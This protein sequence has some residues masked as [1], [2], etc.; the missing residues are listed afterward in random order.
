MGKPK[1]AA[2]NNNLYERVFALLSKNPPMPED[3]LVARL[4]GDSKPTKSLYRALADM[5]REGWVS[6]DFENKLGIEARQGVL[7][8]N[9]RGFGFVVAQEY[10]GDDV[11]IP[12]RLLLSATQDDQ[13][14][15]WV[16]RVAG[17]PGP[18]GRIMDVVIR[19]HPYLVGRLDRLHNGGWRVVPRD[20]RLPAV[21][22]ARRANGE[23]WQ[24]GLIVSC[25]ITRWPI[26]PAQ[27]ARGEVEE[28]L[29][30]V[31]DPGVDMKVLMAERQIKPT[32]PRDVVDEAKSLPDA[33]RDEDCQDREDLRQQL[34]V[35]IDGSDAKDLDDAISVQRTASGYRVGVHIADVSFYV[36]EDSVLDKEARR[37]GT[38]VYL[39]DRVVPMLP[40]RLSNGIAS[41]NPGVPRL[42]LTA[43]VE[44]DREGRRKDARIARTIIQSHRRLTYDY[45]NQLLR[46]DDGVDRP[47]Y[48]L[49]KTAE[50]VRNLLYRNR[51]ERGAVDFDLP[52]AKVLVD[53]NG[54]PTEIVPRS[55][56][57]AESIIEELMLLANEAVAEKLTRHRLP[58]LFRVHDEP[59]GDKL[60][61]F[62][63][64]VGALGYRLPKTLTPKS[65]QKL[66]TTVKGKPEERVIN[67]ALLR[68]M[69]QARYSPVN[70]GHFGLA[71]PKY[72]HF[73]SPIRRYPDLWVHRVL[74][75]HMR[76]AFLPAE[77]RRLRQLAD[78]V[79][80]SSSAREREAMEA[81]RDSVEMK[82]AEYMRERIGDDYQAVIS[83]VTNFGLFVEL[84]NLVEGLVRLEDLPREYWIFDPVRYRLTGERSGRI[85]QLGQ[86]VEVV[87]AGVDVA[88][89]RIDFQLKNVASSKPARETRPKRP[90]RRR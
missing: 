24:S 12:A 61:Q 18:E 68:S 70:T 6:R 46:D 35:T 40:E 82:Q 5:R 80:E 85:F 57:V 9:P 47:L 75:L 63:E 66:L 86:A 50:E 39:V 27:P 42:T 53:E 89:R 14:L 26:E 52:E 29:G 87:V 2:A 25:R 3:T 45:V 10:P 73:T 62:R 69:R 65:L 7:R 15:V 76:G 30:R 43:W 60:E 1:K 11:F 28:V 31:D 72:T 88:L 81:E 33:V 83:G 17:A 84:P 16:R 34:V 78:E 8:V 54:H 38:S 55:R 49:L 48:Q 4:A 20:T 71:S 44:L 77:R 67:S 59:E 58:G 36:P 56:G 32:F 22:V 19:A 21:M 74:T 79:A 64:L 13:V 41:L 90:S 23:R 37:R 51:M